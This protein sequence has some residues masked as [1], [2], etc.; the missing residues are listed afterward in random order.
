MRLSDINTMSNRSSLRVAADVKKLATI[1]QFIEEQAHAL[2]IAPDVV[3]DLVLAANEM[4]T[5]IIVHGYRGAPGTIE[6]EMQRL[7]DAIEIRLRDQATLFDPTRAPTPNMTLPLEK[8][9]LGGMGLYCTRQLVDT[10]HYRV[11]PQKGNELILL[12]RGIVHSPEE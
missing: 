12:K 6:I 8:R 4:A 11:T 3:Y 7:G 1:R 5:N 2:N 10:M 9:P